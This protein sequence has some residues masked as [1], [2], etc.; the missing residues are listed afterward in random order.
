MS[1]RTYH[2]ASMEALK[3]EL[4]NNIPEP[5]PYREIEDLVKSPREKRQSIFRRSFSFTTP[6]SSTE[7]MTASPPAEK[8][9]T[10]IIRYL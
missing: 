10:K 3:R 9:G 4:W 1:D 6:R 2:A 7:N 5:E 8:K